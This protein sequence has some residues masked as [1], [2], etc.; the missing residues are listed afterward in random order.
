MIN[1]GRKGWKETG[2]VGLLIPSLR[3]LAMLP[4]QALFYMHI[5]TLPTYIL[6]LHAFISIRFLETLQ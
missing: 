6:L 4:L 2:C 3:S 1:F 5:C